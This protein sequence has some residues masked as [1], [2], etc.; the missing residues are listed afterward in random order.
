[1]RPAQY[2]L[3]AGKSISVSAAWR[4]RRL[5][6]SAR[7]LAE[8][9]LSRL[10]ALRQSGGSGHSTGSKIMRLQLTLLACLSLTAGA[11]AAEPVSAASAKPGTV[12]R[13]CA[14]CPELVVI[15]PGSF[16]MG[17]PKS[18]THREPSGEEEPQHRVAIAYKL[19]VGRFEVTRDE[20]GVFVQA[21]GLADPDGCNAHIPPRWP[22]MP[23]L[24]WHNTGFAQTGRDPALCMSWTEAVAYTKW[25]SEKTSHAYRL[26]S[27]AEWE[28]AARAGTKGQDY[29]GDSQEAA[30]RYA[31]GPDESL[32]EVIPEQKASWGAILPCRDGF[33][34]TSP[35]G[36]FQP[37]PF[38]L[39][40][41][42]GNAF[43]WVQDC[44]NSS[45]AGAPANGAPKLTGDC[46]KRVNRGGSW[47]SIP[48]GIR[49]AHRGDDN[50]ETTRV[51][52]LGFRVARRLDP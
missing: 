30:C 35:A 17:S 39:Y 45:Y 41:M 47:T 48:T 32:F 43:E 9:A 22:K 10:L 49:S 33:A 25:L 15:P 46:T 36:S 19:A 16:L 24:S 1:M 3:N 18:D 2:K 31:N 29:W 34:Y 21:T 7:S 51:T 12:F 23:G 11:I 8:A 6:G 50:A 42:M 27:E 26:L 13:D 28:Y 40:D 44:W 20:Y 52:D 38:G 4:A 37:N 14:D 5:A